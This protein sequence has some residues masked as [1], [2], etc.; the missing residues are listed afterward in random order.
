MANNR[1]INR[2]STPSDYFIEDGSF[3]R[4]RNIQLGYTFGAEQIKKLGL[5]MLR[6]EIGAND[7]ARF[8]T[9]KQERGLSY[10]YSRSVNFTVNASF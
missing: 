10:P 4:I 2:G 5:S 7:L 6:L 8:C 9:V 1:N 3:F